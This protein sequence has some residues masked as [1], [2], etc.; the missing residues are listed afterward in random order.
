[1]VGAGTA[2]KDDKY[3]TPA[4]TVPHPVQR[5]GSG[6][7]KAG[8]SRLG[9]REGHDPNL[10]RRTSSIPKSPCRAQSNIALMRF[11]ISP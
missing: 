7:C 1:M 2:V 5:H 6:R 8:F 3:G 10:T 9:D 11:F 4:L